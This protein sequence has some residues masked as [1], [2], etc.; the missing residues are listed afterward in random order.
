M[1]TRP[2]E[3]SKSNC[4]SGEPMKMND[5]H[6]WARAIVASALGALALA[7]A[8]KD[9]SP[10]EEGQ[11]ADLGASCYPVAAAGRSGSAGSAGMGSAGTSATA[12]DV[13]TDAGGDSA[14]PAPEGVSAEV[15]QP[16]TDTT[17]NS[18]C[19]GD[20]PI[21]APLPAGPACTQ[22]LCLEGEP[23]AGACPADWPC[24]AIGANPSACLKF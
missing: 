1:M 3:V 13:D 12:D 17:A 24:L 2:S 16:C 10:C 5:K 20:A 7:S 8:C 21:C 22:I 9:D 19:G 18:D 4:R 14:A 11:R 6:S 15:G 23:N